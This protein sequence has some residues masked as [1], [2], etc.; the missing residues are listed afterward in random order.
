M[1]R[2][3]EQLSFTPSAVSQQIAAL[4]RQLGAR[5]LIRH[6]RGVRLTQVGRTLVDGGADLD[7]Q[8]AALEQDAR[9]VIAGRSGRLR[10]A[11]FS[12][13]SGR[14]V[15][16]AVD[17]FRRLHPDVRMTLDIR[18]PQAAADAVRSGDADVGLIFDYP[19]GPQVEIDDLDGRRLVDDP[20]LIA[21]PPSHPLAGRSRVSIGELQNDSWIS[22]CSPDPTC[23]EAL[24]LLCAQAGYRPMVAFESDDY[25]AIGRLVAAEVGVA[26]VPALAVEQM[27]AEVTLLQLRPRVRRRISALRSATAPPVADAMINTLAAVAHDV[28]AAH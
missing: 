8:L 9:D 1:S 3:A 20:M 2:A 7:D 13:A 28:G 5:L 16:A 6:A 14:L 21:V 17:R 4:E 22:D 26:F 10:L 23:R 19:D 12:S 24:W 25:L 27:P 11:A 18:D 15:P